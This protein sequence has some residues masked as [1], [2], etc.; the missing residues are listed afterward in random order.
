MCNELH[1]LIIRIQGHNQIVLVWCHM[2]YTSEVC[3]KKSWG[4]LSGWIYFVKCAPNIGFK[5]FQM[6]VA[7]TVLSPH[8]VE[9][10]GIVGLSGCLSF[11][12]WLSG[13][14]IC[15]R[16]RPYTA[17]PEGRLDTLHWLPTSICLFPHSLGGSLASVCRSLSPS[18]FPL[19]S[20]HCLCPLS[21]SPI[22]RP[23]LPLLPFVSPRSSD[24]GL[25]TGYSTGAPVGAA[26]QGHT[27]HSETPL[28]QVWAGNSHDGNPLLPCS[29]WKSHWNKCM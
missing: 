11:L 20:C 8:A 3:V 19:S 6:C 5:H 18:T 2:L 24:P 13:E 4:E 16:R 12:G 27:V 21:H 25:W 26:K 28:T 15:H 17:S 14:F 1:Q 7:C 22:P 10:L 29:W 9:T 23:L